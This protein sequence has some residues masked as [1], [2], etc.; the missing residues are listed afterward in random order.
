MV[1][2]GDGAARREDALELT[3]GLPPGN[4]NYRPPFDGPGLVAMFIICVVIVL[5][6]WY[7]N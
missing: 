7:L 3:M 6:I 2:L 1:H 5:L 4:K